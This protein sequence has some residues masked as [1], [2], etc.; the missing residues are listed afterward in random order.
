MW[1]HLEGEILG[2]GETILAEGS[3]AIEVMRP[4]EIVMVVNPDSPRERWKESAWPLMERA[5]LVI[6]NE[7]RDGEG[8][9]T[10]GRVASEISRRVRTHIQI[11]DVARPLGEWGDATL[12]RL[13]GN[14]IGAGTFSSPVEKAAGATTRT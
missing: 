1:S 10:A 13:C 7:R 8:R 2:A 12:S 11:Q 5:S 3:K 6:V 4:E 14:V 9:D